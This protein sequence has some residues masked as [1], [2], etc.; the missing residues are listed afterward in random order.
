MYIERL[1]T[2]ATVTVQR[3]AATILA[4]GTIRTDEARGELRAPPG[5]CRTQVPSA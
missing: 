3:Y 2:G 5:R 4:A 1:R